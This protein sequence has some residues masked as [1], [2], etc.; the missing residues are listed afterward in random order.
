MLH[1]LHVTYKRATNADVAKDPKINI[2]VRVG[3]SGLD[4]LDKLAAENRA[5]RS[6]VVRAAMVVASKH[7]TE[8]AAILEATA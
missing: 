2:S 5:D 4:W 3:R 1:L 6:E 8:I 7:P